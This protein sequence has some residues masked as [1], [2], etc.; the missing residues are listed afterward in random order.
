MPRVVKRN[1]VLQ[2]IGAG[3]VIVVAVLPTPDDAARLV[4]F[5]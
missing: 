4:L 3:D 1:I 5:A 2:R